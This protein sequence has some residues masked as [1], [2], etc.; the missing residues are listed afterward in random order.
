M[1]LNFFQGN[2]TDLEVDAIVNAA[3][4][5]LLGGG[6]VDGAI[7]RAAGP[8]LLAECRM[9]NGCKTGKAKITKGYKLKAKHVIHTVGPVWQGGQNNEATLLK[10]CYQNSLE[11]AIENEIK[12]IAFPAI[13]CGVYGY[14]IKK[15]AQIAIETCKAFASEYE[16][17]N[18]TFCLF[19]ESDLEVYQNTN[20]QKSFSCDLKISERIQGSLYGFVVGDALGV[21]VKFITRDQ[22]T[23]SPVKGMRGHG[24]HNQAPGTWSDDTSMTLCTISS[25]INDNF[26]PSSIMSKFVDW[27]ENGFMAAHGKAFD[28]GN[29]T[30]ESIARFKAGIVSN[31]WGC[32]NDWQNGNG[33]LMR[34]LP[35][36]LF[37]LSETESSALEKSF[38]CSALTH[39]HIRAKLACGYFTLLIRKLI[40]GQSLEE[41][42][43]SAN[44]AIVPY[45]PNEEKAHFESILNHSVT[46]KPLQEISSSG[47]VIHTLEAAIHCVATT[48]SY[49]EA[50]LKAVNLGDDTDTTAC[51]TGAIAGIIYGRKGIPNNWVDHLAEL[52]M[53][54]STFNDF[55]EI[56]CNRKKL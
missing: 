36:S 53:L 42:L 54:Q 40:N 19:S 14:P 26:S 50:V 39:A 16:E 22:L 38:L 2:I 13:S 46:K 25:L 6:G 4:S 29:A 30:K 33:S 51:I 27:T 44:T 41:S 20:S 5:S 52:Q 56:V 45:M 34:I 35:L 15:A 43:N 9:L 7:H 48:S 37:T 11:L 17:L 55:N 18:I 8:E 31:E 23:E 12:S 49:E 47:Y 1:A 3:N 28:V 10:L 21:P 32:K 24:T